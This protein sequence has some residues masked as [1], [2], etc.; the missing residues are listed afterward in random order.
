M[1]NG[2][3]TSASSSP[4]NFY[5]ALL[6]WPLRTI[7]MTLAWGQR[8]AAALQRVNEV[9]ARSPT[10]STRRSRSPL[11][12]R[13]T[14][15]GAVT[16]RDVTFGYDAGDEPA[17]RCSTASPRARGRRVG[18]ARRRDR[19][20]Q[21]D[22]RP[23]ARCA[24]TTRST[25]PSRSTASTSATSR[26]TTCGAPSASCSRTRCC[27]TTRSPP[28]SPS[29]IPTRRR[30]IASRPRRDWPAPTTSSME[31]PEGYDTVLG[32]RGFSLSGG[33]RQR[34]AIARAILADP[35]ILVLDDATSAVDPSKEHEIRDAM[36][37]VMHG[38]TT[39]VIAHRPGTIALADT[40]V[41]LD[42]GRVVADGTARRAARHQPALPRRAR[43]DGPSRS[44]T[45]TATSSVDGARGRRR[46]MFGMGAAIS[47]ED[48]LDRDEAKRGVA[49]RGAMAAPFRRTVAGRAGVH[50]ACRRRQRVVGPLLVRYGIDHGIR[51]GD[52][53]ALRP[54]RRRSTSSSRSWPT[55]AA[56]SSTCSS[57][58]PARG[59][60][61]SCASV[62]S[63]TSSAS[64]WPS[65]T[66]TSRA[67][68]CRG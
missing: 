48:R 7:G 13:C 31:L 35:R 12:R 61:A 46:L 47:D 3:L 34:I 30:P 16:F 58:A 27:S 68:S 9:L 37:T 36:Q 10:S 14:P 33:Q 32:E 66:A 56:A 4:F 11:P 53:G 6:V 15:L 44:S 19:L 60:C 23:A 63:T 24:S 22:G 17:G 39:I 50:R 64:R 28:T 20:G 21:V 49:A 2:R 29:P 40:V 1:L 5:V 43:G 62:C 18:R 38:R 26:C 54:R 67:C 52:A 59:S 51:D 55:S 8:A 45:A 41:L 25:A 57:T 42:D 65:S